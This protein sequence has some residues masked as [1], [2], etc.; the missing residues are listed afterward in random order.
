MG[1]EGP[2]SGS[3]LRALVVVALCAVLSATCSPREKIWRHEGPVVLITLDGLRADV[4]GA[5]GGPRGLTPNLDRLWAEADWAG[6]AVASSSWT[7]PSMASL[8][9]GLS[10]WQH[11]ALYGARAQLSKDRL[12]LAEALRQ[13]GFTTSAFRSNYWT[14][15]EFGYAKGFSTYSPLRQG[16][17]AKRQLE[18]LGGGATFVWLELA[19]PSPPYIRTAEAEKAL[20]RATIP[21]GVPEVLPEQ[22]G[23]AELE[24]YFDP[25]RVLPD[26]LRREFWSLYLMS[27]ATGDRWLGTYLSALRESGQWAHTLLVVTSTHGTAFGEY[28]R[29][30]AGGGLGRHLIEVPL[31]IKMPAEAPRR[32]RLAA[33]SR[34]ALRR[35]WATIVEAAGGRPVPAAAPSLFR[36]V[37]DGAL[38]ELYF[39]NGSNHFSWV[40]GDRQVSRSIRFAPPEPEF[41]AARMVLE[42]LLPPAALDEPAANVLERLDRAFRH[43]HPFYGEG[44]TPEVQLLTWTAVGSIPDDDAAESAV[45]SRELEKAWL[46]GA[47]DVT[48]AAGA[49][50]GPDASRR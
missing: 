14:R 35:V 2:Q 31:I 19:E 34:P 41:F 9:T 23:L 10:P 48:P 49:P 22:L 20:R 32:L 26:D 16:Y 7:V 17:R 39:D 3:G 47:V 40:R 29:V 6:T 37:E 25:A 4:V 15:P 24:P 11:Q 13:V 8:M 50:P 42:G 30:G 18:G 28:G 36:D 45:L 5:L 1:K 12:T 33:G 27:V 43:R 46:A 38:S 21:G 44:G